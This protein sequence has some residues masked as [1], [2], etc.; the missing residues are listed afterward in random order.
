MGGRLADRQTGMKMYAGVELTLL[1]LILKL[2][3]QRSIQAYNKQTVTT[4][5]GGPGGY[6]GAF[7]I[8]LCLHVFVLR[9]TF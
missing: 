4:G 2:K 7:S 6:A 5:A 1:F 8:S 3:S 9:P